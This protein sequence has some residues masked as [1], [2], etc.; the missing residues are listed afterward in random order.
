MTKGM[1]MMDKTQLE[2][3]AD[4]LSS[5][6]DRGWTPQELTALAVRRLLEG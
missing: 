1:D 3:L 4:L 2:D 6:K 5:L